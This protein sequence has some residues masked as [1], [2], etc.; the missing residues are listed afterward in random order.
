MAAMD[1]LSLSAVSTG[2]TRRLR[3]AVMPVTT[4]ACLRRMARERVSMRVDLLEGRG[5]V[6]DVRA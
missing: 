1:V 6:V 5:D 4:S 2:T 3:N